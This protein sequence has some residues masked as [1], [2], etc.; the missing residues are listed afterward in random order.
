[1][2]KNTP[3]LFFRPAHLQD[4]RDGRLWERYLI[5]E[6]NVENT[7]GFWD[8][9]GGGEEGTLQVCGVGGR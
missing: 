8:G 3:I 5:N 6:V 7:L 1:M 2:R 9:N 4:L